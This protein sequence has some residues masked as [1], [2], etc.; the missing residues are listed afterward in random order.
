MTVAKTVEEVLAAWREAERV[1]DTLPPMSADHESVRRTVV[2]LRQ[3]YKAITTNAERTTEIIDRT[4]RAITA[5]HE[6]LAKFD[7]K[8][9]AAASDGSLPG[10]PP[11]IEPAS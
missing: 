10:M 11:R 8:S 2:D 1:L 9:D 6:V 7:G 4:H 3:T 5:A